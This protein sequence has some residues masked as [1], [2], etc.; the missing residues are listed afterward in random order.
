MREGRGGTGHRAKMSGMPKG[1]P[2][3]IRTFYYNH[4]FNDQ[5]SWGNKRRWAPYHK[6]WD[7]QSLAHK[8]QHTDHPAQHYNGQAEFKNQPSWG[9]KRRWA[10]YHK[11]W[12]NQSLAHKKQRTDHPAQHYNGQAEFKNQP[13]WGKKR[14]S[15]PYHDDW[16]NQSVAH[17][18]KRLDDPALHNN[19]RP[20][21]KNRPTRGKKRR[22][23]PRQSMWHSQRTVWKHEDRSG[24]AT[25]QQILKSF[26]GFKVKSSVAESTILDLCN[27]LMSLTLS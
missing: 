13:S 12:D 6:D 10:P 3:S 22:W 18:E 2:G 24:R 27:A 8:K 20:V 26:T 9:N 7:N 5:P 16:D 14:R 23:R 15:A 21:F 17:K 19:G 4:T 1:R 11:D 25:S